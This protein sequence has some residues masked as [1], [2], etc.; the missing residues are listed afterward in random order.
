MANVS[1]NSSLSLWGLCSFLAVG[2]HEASP[3]C[4]YTSLKIHLSWLHHHPLHHTVLLLS[5]IPICHQNAKP[6]KVQTLSHLLFYGKRGGNG[7]REQNREKFL[8]CGYGCQSRQGAAWTCWRT[9]L[10]G[11]CWLW[12]QKEAVLEMHPLPLKKETVATHMGTAWVTSVITRLVCPA[13]ALESALGMFMRFEC[14]GFLEVGGQEAVWQGLARDRVVLI[15]AH[16]FL[17]SLS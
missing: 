13:L 8:S 12:S 17:R 3:L 11:L 15:W 10:E 2:R 7:K 5:T 14:C 1:L 4:F 9:V 6:S 16:D